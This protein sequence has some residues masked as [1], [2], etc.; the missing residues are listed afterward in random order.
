ML[1]ILRLSDLPERFIPYL[2]AFR[3]VAASGFLVLWFCNIGFFGLKEPLCL[4]CFCRGR[5][6]L[7]SV[8][9]GGRFFRRL[10]PQ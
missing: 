8:R 4:L 6:A 7:D 5:L 10:L 1:S 9:V 3:L 2:V